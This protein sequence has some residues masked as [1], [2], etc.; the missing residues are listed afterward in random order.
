MSAEDTEALLLLIVLMSAAAESFGFIC[1]QAEPATVG[2]KERHRKVGA[3]SFKSE[4]H[5]DVT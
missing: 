1:S 5:C 3:L 4:E 2:D